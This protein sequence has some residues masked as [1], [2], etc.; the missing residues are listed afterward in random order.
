[1]H[2]Q[3][4]HSKDKDKINQSIFNITEGEMFIEIVSDSALQP[5]FKKLPTEFWWNIKE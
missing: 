2:E 3:K 5:I 4:I 1:M